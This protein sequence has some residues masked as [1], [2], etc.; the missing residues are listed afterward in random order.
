MT[1]CRAKR[2]TD[3]TGMHCQ[4]RRTPILTAEMACFN[5]D[6][7][8]VVTESTWVELLLDTANT[9]GENRHDINLE[10]PSAECRSAKE[11]QDVKANREEYC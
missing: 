10:S 5:M 11:R 7:E 4:T 1:T 6:G 9:P 2:T 8:N 3:G